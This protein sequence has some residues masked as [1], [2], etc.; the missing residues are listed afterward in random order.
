VLANGITL[1]QE[2]QNINLATGP[3]TE[4]CPSINIGTDATYSMKLKNGKYMTV[5]GSFCWAQGQTSTY[6]YSQQVSGA[7]W[8]DAVN[9]VKSITF[10]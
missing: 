2:K 3:T 7:E 1:W 9:V 4:N 10:Q 6:S 8:A 5:A